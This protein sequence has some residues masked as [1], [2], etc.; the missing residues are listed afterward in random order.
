MHHARLDQRRRYRWAFCINSSVWLLQ[1]YV[2]FGIANSL[3]L[4]GDAAH[5]VSDSLVLL[6]TWLLISATI[7]YP[8]KDHSQVKRLLT[9]GAVV[10]L[11]CSAAYLVYEGYGRIVSPIHFL[12]WPIVGIALVSAI[13]NYFSHKLIDGVDKSLHDHVHKANVLHILADLFISAAVAFSGL[14]TIFLHWPALDGWVA[15]IVAIW[16]SL[17][18]VTLWRETSHKTDDRDHH[19]EEHRH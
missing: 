5:S 10:L 1:T 8:T 3:A 4:L 2:V 14:G 6:G 11:W 13:G 16:M 15:F 19:N 17:R 18:G 12:G 9:R 7:K